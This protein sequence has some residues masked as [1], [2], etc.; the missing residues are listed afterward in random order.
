M[1]WFKYFNTMNNIIFLH[2][3]GDKQ[4]SGGWLSTLRQ[5]TSWSR[6]PGFSL[7]Y[8]FH[9]LEK[10]PSPLTHANYHYLQKGHTNPHLKHSFLG[11]SVYEWGLLPKGFLDSLLHNESPP[12]WMHRS[13]T[14][15]SPGMLSCSH[16]LFFFASLEQLL[17]PRS[18]SLSCA[19][20]KG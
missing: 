11:H 6:S 10:S 3:R 9:K 13:Q 14:M 18:P 8:K 15:V 17:W 12:P 5:F 20:A 4:L 7:A 2:S 1:T 16:K 19:N